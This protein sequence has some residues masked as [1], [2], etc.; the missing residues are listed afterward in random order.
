MLKARVTPFVTWHL[1]SLFIFWE[2]LAGSG[3]EG[4]KEKPVPSFEVGRQIF[5]LLL[6]LMSRV[7]YVIGHVTQAQPIRCSAP[8]L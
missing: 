7:S 8:R 2:F 5:A 3:M 6:P 1:N 4:G